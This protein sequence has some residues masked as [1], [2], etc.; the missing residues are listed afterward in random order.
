MNKEKTRGIHTMKT[1]GAMLKSARLAKGTTLKDVE[2][3]IKIREKFILAIEAD[4]FRELPS[5]SYAKGF[6]HNYAEYLGLQTDAVMA[7]FRRQMTEAPGDSLLPKGVSD[8]LNAPFLHLT[9]GRF[10]GMLVG[11]LLLVFLVYLGGQY[12]R[13]NQPPPLT[14]KTPKNQQIF[15]EQHV[16]VEGQTDPDATVSVNGVSTVVRDDGRFYIQVAI[17]PG[18]NTLTIIAVSRFGKTAKANLEVGYSPEN[19]H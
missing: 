8:P 4:N 17:D 14:I 7:F 10:I 1:V 11:I 13:V 2:R 6:V 19:S 15:E 5:P 3:D 9:P 12:F 16:A 18:V